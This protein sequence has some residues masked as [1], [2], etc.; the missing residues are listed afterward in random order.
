[1]NKTCEFC[2]SLNPI[3]YCKADSAHLCL[4][5][6][7][8]VH[9]ANA[10]SYRHPRTLVCESCKLAPVIVRCMDHHMFTCHKCDTNGHNHND[11]TGHQ[12]RVV[13]C[14]VGCPSA[15]DLAALWGF[16]S[17]ELHSSFVEIEGESSSSYIILQQIHE[18]EKTQPLQG[19]FDHSSL[20]HVRER[21]HRLPFEH[22]TMQKLDT[23]HFGSDIDSENK[24]EESSPFS[25]LENF[26]SSVINN[27]LQGDS[28]WPTNEIW[29]QNMQELGVYGE[30]T[31]FDASDI[32]DVDLTF[33]NFEEFFGNEH[34]LC[35]CDDDENMSCS[36]G[37]LDTGCL[38]KIEE[39]EKSSSPVSLDAV[40]NK[41]DT[42]NQVRELQSI[43]FS[44]DLDNTKLDV[45]GKAKTRCKE[46]KV[47]RRENQAERTLSTYV[48]E[49]QETKKRTTLEGRRP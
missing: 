40:D 6:D 34:D 3:V 43:T 45:K 48:S 1:M 24:T 11:S 25:Q 20:P 5:C 38:S 14:Y 46:T 23:D 10:L 8:K 22:D 37:E 42:S 7:A 27:P 33:R 2:S 32:P 12:R 41:I 17:D 13:S 16:G 30:V 39:I 26:T 19:I 15:R 36:F 18:L 21:T 44:Y 31:C 4:S 28:F 47:A 35:I 29:L 49:R 9:S